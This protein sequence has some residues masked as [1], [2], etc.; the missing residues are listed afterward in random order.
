MVRVLT[1]GFAPGKTSGRNTTQG[2]V[3]EVL[4]TTGAYSMMRHPLY[5]GNYLMWLGPV[6]FLRS[7]E[8]AIIFSLLYWLYYERIMFAEE[9][10]LRKKFVDSYDKW[11]ERVGPFLPSFGNYTRPELSFSLKTVI[12][13]EYTSFLAIFITFGFLDFVRNYLE[14]RELRL[15]GFWLYLLASALII[16]IVVRIIH[17]GTNLLRV[18]G[19]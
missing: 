9:Q 19:R 4:N 18:E 16:W 13:R 14:N 15:S 11:S 5:L 17:K 12:R 2:Q 8:M 1:V 3:A 6:L 10:F 7:A